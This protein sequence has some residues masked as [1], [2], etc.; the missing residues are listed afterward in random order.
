MILFLI[1]GILCASSYFI[2]KSASPK[3]NKRFYKVDEVYPNLTNIY[4]FDKQIES[5]VLNLLANKNS[6]LDWPEKNLYNQENYN[7]KVYPF[8]AFGTW[9]NSNCKTC[10]TISK[11]LKSIKGLKMA[12]LSKLSSGTKLVPHE[13]YASHS[14]Y[15]LRCHYPIILPKNKKSSKIYVGENYDSK[16][17]SRYY[18]KFKWIIFDDAKVHYSENLGESDRIVLLLDIERPNFVEVGKCNGNDTKEFTEIIMYLKNN[19]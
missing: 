4:E 11:F 15:I 2:L 12:G 5:E 3:L 13:G 19:S 10:P 16:F 17:E 1:I 7:W 9:I 18:Q 6:W 14:N 8:Y